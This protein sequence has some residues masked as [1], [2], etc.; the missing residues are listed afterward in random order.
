MKNL[1]PTFVS[2]LFVTIFAA[3]SCS[4]DT[5]DNESVA[6]NDSK[7]NNTSAPAATPPKLIVSNLTGNNSVRVYL[8]AIFAQY[9]TAP[10]AEINHKDYQFA[11][12]NDGDTYEYKNYVSATPIGAPLN[13]WVVNDYVAIPN[14]S[15][16]LTASA[17]QGG[18]ADPIWQGVHL[19]VRYNGTLV[20]IN[21]ADNGFRDLIG[22]PALGNFNTYMDYIL[23]TS[24][25]AAIY[26]V[27]PNTGDILIT[28]Q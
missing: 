9:G 25:I 16:T 22:D 27:D 3:S 4:N 18:Y 28:V 5:K 21:Y 12:I 14:T 20:P 11:T 1:L 24:T 13:W 2:I 8:N 19:T 15:T 7:I 6:N 23:P 10:D 17:T 26:S